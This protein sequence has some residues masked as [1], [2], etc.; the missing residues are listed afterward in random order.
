MLV[1]ENGAINIEDQANDPMEEDN[2]VDNIFE[3]DET[4]ILIKETFNNVGMDDDGNQYDDRSFDLHVLEREIKPLYEGSK[5]SLL[6][7]VLLLVNL[8]VVNGL[9]NTC[10]IQLLRYVIYFV[11]FNT[12][13]MI[14][15]LIFFVVFSVC[16]LICIISLV[17]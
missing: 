11:S 5:T 14:K 9:S 2:D 8:K 3:E 12:I 15:K 16:T 4:N 6:F 17:R 10:V 13:Y 1:Q 7:V